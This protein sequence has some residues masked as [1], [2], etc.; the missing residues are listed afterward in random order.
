MLQTVKPDE[1][2]CEQILNMG[3][4]IE[5]V[6]D[7][8]KNTS[9][10]MQTAIDNLLKMQADGTYADALKELLKNVNIGQ[11]P[12]NDPNAPST[13]TMP[14]TSQLLDQL[15]NH[16]E[17]MDVRTNR[18]NYLFWKNGIFTMKFQLIQAYERFSEDIEH[19]DN[20][21][22]DLPLTEERTLLNEYKKMLNMWNIRR[23]IKSN[24]EII[25]NEFVKV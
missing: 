18:N 7:A 11:N 12:R 19:E 23:T 9:N 20:A 14:S 2:L 5:L 10:D 6:R 1:N 21:Y 25:V 8:L 4:D 22:L 13:S 3:F 17:E 15:Q 24:R 16:E